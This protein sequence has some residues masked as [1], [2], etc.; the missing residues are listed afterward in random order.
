MVWFAVCALTKP[1]HLA[2]I[3]L[4]PMSRTARGAVAH[5]RT[6]I[7]VALPAMILAVSWSAVSSADVA[8][9][10]LTDITGVPTEQFGPIWK[11]GYMLEQ[12]AHFPAALL[13]AMANVGELWR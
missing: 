6:A 11:L 5:W 12:P 1:P 2:F 8:A 9:W 7:I 10:R 13:A 3:L 4:E